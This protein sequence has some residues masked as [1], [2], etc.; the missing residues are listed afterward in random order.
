MEVGVQDDAEKILPNL[1]SQ[2]GETELE[3]RD[4]EREDRDDS[5]S[6]QEITKF[7]QVGGHHGEF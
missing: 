3:M 1:V 7:E 4:A 6:S 5:S 2:E